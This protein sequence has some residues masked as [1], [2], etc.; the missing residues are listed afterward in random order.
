[1]PAL[2]SRVTLPS[3]QTFRLSEQAARQVTTSNARP[4]SCLHALQILQSPGV[5]TSNVG[6]QIDVLDLSLRDAH[7]LR[8]LLT[9][10]SIV[11]EE[12]AELA[13]ENCEAT[14]RVAPSTLLE[15]GPF[16]DDELDD[17]EL[18][19]PFEHDKPHRIPLVFVGKERA[20]SVR[21]S[22]R[23][24]REALPLWHAE[25]SMSFR[26]TP[27][28]V[29]AMGITALGR[30]RRATA[31]ADALSS[32]SPS[33]YQAIVDLLYD[34]H[35]SRRLVGAYRCKSCGARNDLD[36]PWVREIPYE[37]ASE[38]KTRR[39]FPD[40]DTFEKMVEQAAKR[41]YRKHH[42]RNIDL[43]VDDGVPAC[44]DGGQ[45]LLGYYSPGTSEDEIGIARPPEIRIFY[46]SFDTEH[47]LDPSFDVAAEIEE[48]I[49]HEVT[50][51]LHFLSG[52]DPVD[53][54]E[55]A[56]IAD[57]EI[58]RI[59]KREVVRRVSKGFARDVAEFF[60]VAWPLLALAFF[61]TWLGFC[62]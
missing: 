61:A 8:A 1:M 27:S 7:V 9:Y 22:R 46:R 33:A 51:H 32:A 43:V 4:G 47:R 30:E 62:R 35:Y 21:I 55:R 29:T 44:D 12:P 38:R 49:D 24:L 28:I 42:V 52:D 5:V 50:H 48:T 36:V 60:R 18:D 45:P 26:F 25:D 34:A 41:I 31:I 20:R 19:A 11:P 53:Y 40:I 17:A 14:F 54:E 3:G 59:G 57:E 6:A 23:T 13:C 2:P 37:G 39:A 16:V 56:Q 10:A 15:V 58:R